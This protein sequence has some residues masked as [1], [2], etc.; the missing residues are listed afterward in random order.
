[1]LVNFDG[2]EYPQTPVGTNQKVTSTMNI[3]VDTGEFLHL[4]KYNSSKTAVF[5][6]N[7]HS[8]HLVRAKTKNSLSLTLVAD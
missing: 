3:C 8:I 7:I 1:M 2:E 4:L 5:F 6:K